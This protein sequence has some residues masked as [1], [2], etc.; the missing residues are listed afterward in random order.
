[1][2]GFSS[3]DSSPELELPDFSLES[4]LDRELELLLLDRFLD[5]RLGGDGVL[6]LTFLSGEDFSFGDGLLLGEGSFSDDVDLSLLFG[7]GVFSLTTRLSTC[8][9]GEGDR[10]FSFSVDGDRP[11]PLEI[12]GDSFV[13]LGDEDS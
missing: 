8:L 11:S 10:L 3:S 5:E 6:S 13:S 2:A 1:M 7:E 4:D 12:S 9:G